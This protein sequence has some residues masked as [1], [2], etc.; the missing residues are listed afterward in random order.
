M[1]IKECPYSCPTCG[2]GDLAGG[3]PLACRYTCGHVVPR[4]GEKAVSGPDVQESTL[5]D[6][7]TKGSPSFSKK[8]LKRGYRK[9]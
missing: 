4:G 7:S 9:T 2:E 6:R 8:E 5:T 1:P 3:G